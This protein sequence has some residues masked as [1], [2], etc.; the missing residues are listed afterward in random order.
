MD[1]MNVARDPGGAG[2]PGDPVLDVD[3]LD[4]VYRHPR[5]DVLA[6]RDVSLNLRAG[7]IVGV[8]GESGSGKSS[9]LKALIGQ[10]AR[11]ASVT[12]RKLSLAGLPVLDSSR[13]QVR[14]HL[15][16]Y[17][18]TV[19]QDPVNALNPSIT[20]RRQFNRFFR[21]HRTD[22]RKSDYEKET[23]NLLGAVGID[24]RGKLDSYPFEFSQ[25][26]LQRV[27][28]A[29]A[30]ASPEVRLILADEATSSLDVTIQAQ[31]LDL[32][33][34]IRDERGIAVLIITHDV[35]VISRACDQVI[36]MY[37][38]RVVEEATAK[39]IQEQPAHPYS[40]GLIASVPTFPAD[41]TRLAEIRGSVP[42]L[43]VQAAGCTFAPRCRQHLGRVCD[44][45]SPDL[46]PVG[47]DG[48]RAACHLYG[49]A[50]EWEEVTASGNGGD[51]R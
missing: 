45:Q 32:L 5:G 50:R 36:V 42:D 24:G 12:A 38:G 3:G 8:I 11:N 10:Q 6:V 21:L 33:R 41:G 13:R 16:R 27:M 9:V 28:I 18:G 35:G 20:V 22:L 34:R 2:P 17:I 30:T 15:G 23:L 26:Q 43:R 44:E 14:P 4:V 25:G 39:A 40:A 7:E 48:R 29:L 19:F 47:D 31:I 46:F 1:E 51:V 49:P 37:G